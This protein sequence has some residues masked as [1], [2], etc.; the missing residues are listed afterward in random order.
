MKFVGGPMDGRDIAITEG[1][2]VVVGPAQEWDD[3]A[4]VI[5]PSRPQDMAYHRTH[6]Q[7]S[8][9]TDPDWWMKGEPEPTFE[10]I[11]E[12]HERDWVSPVVTAIR[13]AVE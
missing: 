9:S 11:F 5:R 10:T 8:G 4:L 2:N 6:R 1:V 3:E 12:W 13:E 7:V